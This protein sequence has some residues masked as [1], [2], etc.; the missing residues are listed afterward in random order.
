MNHLG[1]IQLYAFR[2]ERRQLIPINAI[3]L[4][5]EQIAVHDEARK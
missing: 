1:F 5:I 4:K 3:L 2:N